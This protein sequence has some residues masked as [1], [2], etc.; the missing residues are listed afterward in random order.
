M[1]DFFT[2]SSG[3]PGCVSVLAKGENGLNFN[4][5]SRLNPHF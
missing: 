4:W 3:H 2:T 5:R 1:G